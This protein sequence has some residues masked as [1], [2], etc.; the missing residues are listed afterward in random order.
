MLVTVLVICKF[1][2]DSIKTTGAIGVTRPN[3]GIY[4]TQTHNNST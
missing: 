1:H 2:N 3:M 4:G